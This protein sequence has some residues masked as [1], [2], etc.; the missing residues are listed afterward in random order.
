M[1]GNWWRVKLIGILLRAERLHA[2]ELIVAFRSTNEYDSSAI[3]NYNSANS[4]ENCG[5]CIELADA[6]VRAHNARDDRHYLSFVLSVAIKF[7]ACFIDAVMIG[8]CDILSVS[9]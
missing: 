4:E 3:G 9:F 6:E 1:L 5:N 8:I 7:G 2:R